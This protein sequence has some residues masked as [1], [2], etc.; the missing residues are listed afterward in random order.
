MT[1]MTSSTDIPFSRAV[2]PALKNSRNATEDSLAY[3]HGHT[4]GYTA[5]LRQAFADAEE[6]RSIMEAE[7]AALLSHSEARTGRVLAAL[8]AAAAAL[9][10]AVVPVI[11]EAQDTLAASALDLAEAILGLELSDADTAARAALARASAVPLPTGTRTVRMHPADLSVLD[12]HTRAAAGVVFVGDE[13]L[14]RGDAFT[15]FETGYLDARIRT[16]MERAR[17]ALSGDDI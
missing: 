6:R 4:A 5:G 9:D 10:A 11:T 15:E 13:T 14:D 17:Q 2:F 8:A 12:D 16:A 7:H 3:A 1:K